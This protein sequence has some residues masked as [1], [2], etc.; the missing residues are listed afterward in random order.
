MLSFDLIP[1]STLLPHSHKEGALGRI[2]RDLVENT[3]LHLKINGDMDRFADSCTYRP[4]H[5]FEVFSSPSKRE[6][7]A[8]WENTGLWKY[9]RQNYSWCFL[10]RGQ[11]SPVWSEESLGRIFFFEGFQMPESTYHTILKI[12]MAGGKIVLNSTA[13][14][15]TYRK[16][17]E[18][19]FLENSIQVEKINFHCSLTNALLGEGQL[20]IVEM[21][22]LLDLKEGERSLFWDKI[23]HLFEIN[24]LK[25]PEVEGI[26]SYWRSRTVSYEELNYEE[27]RHLHLYNTT[28]YKKKMRIPLLK[29]F[30][31]LRVVDQVHGKINS[32]TD[33]LEVEFLPQGSLE[34]EFGVFS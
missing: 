10:K 2:L 18:T 8:G 11:C 27:I 30:R 4:L 25:I 5:F 32:Y 34:I 7:Q 21:E 13:M 33:G 3:A 12:F 29:N 28:S 14:A 15:E 19:F 6:G 26:L 16:R 1:S 9:L 17:L 24:F 23:I 22:K 20:L 31:L